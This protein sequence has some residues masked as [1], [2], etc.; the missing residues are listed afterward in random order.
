MRA[1][2][3][4]QRVIH[5]LIR[6]KRT[7]ALMFVAPVLIMFLMKLIFTQSTTTSVTV[8]TVGVDGNVRSALN[9]V[10][11]VAVTNKASNAAAQHALKTQKVDAVIRQTKPAH[12]TVTYANTDATKTNLVKAGFNAALTAN[13]IKTLKQTTLKLSQTVSQMA[14]TIAKVA[15]QAAGSLKVPQTE[16]AAATKITDRYQYGDKDTGFF[17]K[18]VPILMGF[19]VFFFVFLISG[20][21]LL[22]ERTTGTLDRLLATPVRRGEIV[23]GY[24]LSYGILALIQTVIIVLC[25]V[26][27]MGVE[28]TGTLAAVMVINFLLALVALAFGILLSTLAQSEFQMMQFIPILVIPQVFFSGIVPLDSLAAW[29]KDISYVLPLT[30]AGHAMTQIIMYGT[31]LSALGLDIGVLLLFLIVL[32]ALNVRGMRRYRKV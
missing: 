5:E 19:F 21:A 26:G 27:F 8:A 31:R 10:K 11:H 23:M 24:M 15:P 30:Y 6:D 9:A 12:Y 4:A 20:M 13:G 14:T 3:I 28:I 22:K 18:I 29:V 17:N 32:T 7:M 1:I 2:Y 16:P 25:T